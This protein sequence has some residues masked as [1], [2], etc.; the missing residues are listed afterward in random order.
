MT[1]RHLPF[2]I[3]AAEEEH[4]ERAASRLGIAQSALSRRIKAMEDELGVA[5]FERFPRG[6]RLSPAGKQLYEDTRQLARNFQLA[7]DRIKRLAMGVEGSLRVGINEIVARTPI[8]L[9]LIQQFRAKHPHIELDLKPLGSRRQIE[10]LASGGLDVGF[11][12]RSPLDP[13]DLTF[14]DLGRHSYVLAMPKKHPLGTRKVIHLR[15][16]ADEQFA[17]IP[18]SVSAAAYDNLMNACIAKGLSPRIVYDARAGEGILSLACLGLAVGFVNAER[19]RQLNDQTVLVRR[20]ADLDATLNFAMAW[21]SSDRS[22][23]LSKF[24]ALSR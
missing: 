16:L 6:V 14:A 3:A 15:D 10:L 9:K 13:K 2:F 20:V 4:F 7:T 12:Y 5:L 1:L 24:L 18:R 11:V 23:P 8:V 21:R 22:T 19:V 17:W